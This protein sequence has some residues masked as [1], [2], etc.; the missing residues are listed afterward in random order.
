MLRRIAS[1]L[2]LAA[3]AAWPAGA[4]DAAARALLFAD[5]ADLADL[6]AEARER[7]ATVRELAGALELDAGIA[8]DLEDRALRLELLPDP[9]LVQLAGGE[10]DLREHPLDLPAAGDAPFIVAADGLPDAAFAD[11]LAA[12]GATVVGALPP[13][14]FLVRGDAASAGRIAGLPGVAALGGFDP[15]FKLSRRL[16]PGPLAAR[17]EIALFAGA[18]PGEALAALRS[19]GIEAE[20]LPAGGRTVIAAE[21]PVAARAALAALPSVEAIDAAPEAALYNN[22][23]RVVMQTTK[24]H[25]LGN[26]AFYNPVYAIGVWG[27]SQLVTAADSGVANHEV[28]FAPAKQIPAVAAGPCVTALGDWGNHG[29]GVAATLLGDRISAGGVFGTA[30][31][32]DGVAIRSQLAMQ[33][34]EDHLGN[35]CPPLDTALGLF[36]PAWLTGSLIHTNSWGH[37]ATPN[38]PMAGSY[39]WRS[40][41]IDE[42]LHFPLFRE[43]SVL[44]AV[45]NAGAHW[46]TGSYLAFT[47]SDEAHA[48][49]AIAVGG[50][51]NGNLRDVMYKFSSHG[52]T[53]DCL[54]APCNGLQRVKP[55]VVAPADKT[56][57][58]ADDASPTAYSTFSGTSIA[59]PAVAGAAALVRD[60]FAQGKYP[61][62]PTD[63]PL[64]GPPSSALVKAMLVNAT[65]P[66]YDGSAYQGNA[67]QGLPANAYPNYDQGY[68]RPTLDNVLE[69]AGYR[70]L[71]VFEDAT[72]TSQTGDVWTRNVRLTQKWAGTCNNLRV[73]LVW[74]DEIGT[75]A[76]G[77]KLVNDLDLEVTY[78]GV[79]TRGNHRLTGGAWDGVNN[80]EDVF[81]P[82]GY[83]APFTVF[84]VTI[85]VYGRSV[86]AGPQPWAVVLTYGSCA[87]QTPCPPPPVFA[88]CYR[89]PGDVVP[90]SAWLP[91]VPGCKDQTY[92][93]GEFAGGY[94]PYPR[95]EPPHIVVPPYQPIP[96]EPLPVGH[97]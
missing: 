72:T 63:P 70:K 48:K 42:Y 11:R 77:P 20:V 59:A 50:S 28:F 1:T 95:C 25:Y 40:Q 8:A 5:P 57:D 79:T 84:P 27:A 32:L 87:D 37:N 73:T 97:P 60:Y 78:Q 39:S 82:K 80:V 18:D 67:A 55:D 41:R 92:S 53:N 12:A 69:P 90:G 6:A 43:H 24:A 51:W 26:Q 17:S 75:L 31:N 33:D 74:N 10:I 56:V 62:D 15:S 49:N 86:P 54:G 30:N 88:G 46:T 66:L 65:V 58:T 71:K 23:V 19:L 36:A 16:S 34:I 94:L 93:I 29:T 64:G 4:Q 45:G 91:P 22:E 44:F 47:L 83:V 13:S 3:L 85:R 9:H 81:V 96:G 21:L 68:G 52:P 35:F 38:V 89:G 7:G 61:N 14:S 76:A 2:L